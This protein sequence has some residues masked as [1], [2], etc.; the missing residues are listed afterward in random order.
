M[1][2]ASRFTS[3]NSLLRRQLATDG[4]DGD[5]YED[6]QLE[7]EADEREE[8]EE[9]GEEEEEEEGEWIITQRR[10]AEEDFDPNMV[11]YSSDEDPIEIETLLVPIG[12]RE[13]NEEE[14]EEVQSEELIRSLWMRHT[15]SLLRAKLKEA[16]LK[17]SGNKKVLVDRLMEA[18]IS[19]GNR[20]PTNMSAADAMPASIDFSTD[21]HLKRTM[22]EFNLSSGPSDDAKLLREPLHIFKAILG[23]TLIGAIADDTNR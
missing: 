11:D 16:N 17:S 12:T 2:R 1:P 19:P 23:E 20:T 6:G 4:E 5:E 15:V 22:A 9:E 7:E 8:E 10:R 14:M 18:G 3:V 21:V 13:E